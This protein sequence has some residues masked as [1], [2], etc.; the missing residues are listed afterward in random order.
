MLVLNAGLNNKE[1][2]F[3]LFGTWQPLRTRF[4]V[5]VAHQEA[6]GCLRAA[7]VNGEGLSRVLLVW[8]ETLL[9]KYP[10]QRIHHLPVSTLAGKLSMGASPL[11]VPLLQNV[12]P[13]A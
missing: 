4:E 6:M 2:D 9:P 3:L 8:K 13:G 5:H 10:T 7:L 1:R 12:T 11:C